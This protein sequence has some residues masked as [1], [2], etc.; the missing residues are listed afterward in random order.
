MAVFN[1]SL[2]CSHRLQSFDVTVFDPLKA[3]YRTSMIEWMTSNPC[4]TV[5]VYNV[6]QF[7]KDAY[8]AAFNM[9]NI[10]SRFRN[11]GIWLI[12][13]RI[14]TDE[15]FL[16]SFVIDRPE[17]PRERPVQLRRNFGLSRRQAGVFPK[18]A[19]L[20]KRHSGAAA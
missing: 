19:A 11:M 8:Y 20:S 12:N 6:V 14:F 18:R 1:F 15:D 10:T 7:A 3:C 5:T 9:S 17:R 16:P 2:H 4:K 13:K